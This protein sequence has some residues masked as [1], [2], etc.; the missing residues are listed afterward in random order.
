MLYVLLGVALVLGAA[1]A[2]SAH[3]GAAI[4]ADHPPVG[5]FTTVDGV[6]LHHVELGPRNAPTV[7]LLH[8]ASGNLNDPVAALADSLGGDLRI[9]AVDRPGHGWSERGDMEAMSTPAAQ[10]GLV[11]ELLEEI[12]AGPAVVVGH[13]WSGALALA[14]ALDH[15]RL[16]AGLVLLAPAS[17]PWPGSVSWYSSLGSMPV[18]GRLFTASIVLPV[19]ER[20]IEAA[21]RAVFAPQVPPEDYAERVG[22]LMALRP[23]SFRA[24]ALD[25]DRLKPFLARQSRRYGEISVPTVIITGTAD[26]TVSPEIHSRALAREIAGARLVELPGV[27][28]MPH[29]AEPELIADHIRRLALRAE[30]T[31]R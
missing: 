4:S 10:A 26:E 30:T 11:A 17:H 28:H 24:N 16:V 29:H 13:S 9:V 18:V 7:L 8:G 3:R 21:T 31:A 20:A 12:G 23:A 5:R 1:A 2:Y 19:G 22:T 14:L 25:I 6:R 27:G 15:P